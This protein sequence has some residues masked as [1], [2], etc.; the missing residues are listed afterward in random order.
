M[1]NPIP[2]KWNPKK[3]V[4]GTSYCFDENKTVGSIYWTPVREKFTR[5]EKVSDEDLRKGDPGDKLKNI[6]VRDGILISKKNGCFV[7]TGYKIVACPNGR[8]KKST[9]RKRIFEIPK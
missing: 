5:G 6:V 1:C 8:F 7:F 2:K 4:L 9:R 3:A